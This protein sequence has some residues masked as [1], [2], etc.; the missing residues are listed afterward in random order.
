MPAGTTTKAT[1]Q[2]AYLRSFRVP[3]PKAAVAAKVTQMAT[4][5]G[6]T[7]SRLVMPTRDTLAHYEVLLE[8]FTSLVE[9]KKV[10]DRVDQ[11]I[12]TAKMRLGLR[13]SETPVEMPMDVDEDGHA[14][15]TLG[16]G[17]AHSVVSTRSGRSRKQASVETRLCLAPLGLTVI[18]HRRGLLIGGQCRCLLLTPRQH[19]LPVLVPRDR[20]SVENM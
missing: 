3:Y 4:E 10:A 11:D 16:E 17:R 8:A 7:L 14:L 12:R 9:M 5:L 20:S 18:L 1:H 6:I 2:A 15:D 13:E 19:L